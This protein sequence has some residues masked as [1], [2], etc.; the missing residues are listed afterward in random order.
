MIKSRKE[1]IN[2]KAYFFD[3]YLEKRV[4]SIYQSV[5]TINDQFQKL[6]GKGT[7]NKSISSSGSN[8]K[9]YIKSESKMKV[10]L[11]LIEPIPVE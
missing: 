1:N 6:W 11:Y 3:T 9:N 2:K 5:L 8:D 4:L 10:D 7:S